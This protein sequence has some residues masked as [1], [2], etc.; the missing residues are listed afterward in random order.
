M[1]ATSSAPQTGLEH[2]GTR[3]LR[4]RCGR[5]PPSE[6]AS[7]RR[8]QVG[9]QKVRLLD[10][11]GDFLSLAFDHVAGLTIEAVDELAALL[12]LGIVSDVF[13]R[14]HFGTLPFEEYQQGVPL[15]VVAV[16]GEVRRPAIYELNGEK[17]LPDLVRESWALS[18][19]CPL[20]PETTARWPRPLRLI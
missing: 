14:K 19:R 16:A 7:P 12:H 4:N 10:E 13:L 2:A 11:L 3:P 9:R 8:S 15:L 5:R 20:T 1:A 17:T 18:L 6:R